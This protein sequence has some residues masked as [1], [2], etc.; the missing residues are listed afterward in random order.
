MQ[1]ELTGG[2]GPPFETLSQNGY[3]TH[4]H[5]KKPFGNMIKR[6]KEILAKLHKLI[7]TSLVSR[8][9]LSVLWESKKVLTMRE[10][11]S[12]LEFLIT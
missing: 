4:T 6:M 7:F 1:K 9:N 10:A 2:R 5:P 8:V 3:G 12:F 11:Q